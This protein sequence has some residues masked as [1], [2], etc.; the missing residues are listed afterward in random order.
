MDSKHAARRFHT[1]ANHASGSGAAGVPNAAYFQNLASGLAHLTEVVQDV[2]TRLARI[3]GSLNSHGSLTPAQVALI[4]SA[5]A[6]GLFSPAGFGSS[7]GPP[8]MLNNVPGRR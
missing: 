1:A 4:Q 2:Q 5:A 6:Q 3:E 8:G 7:M